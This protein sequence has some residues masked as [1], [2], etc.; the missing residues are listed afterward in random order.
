MTK[1]TQRDISVVEIF[2]PAILIGLTI[3]ETEG[4]LRNDVS[5]QSRKCVGNA[6]NSAI[7]PAA[8]E[9]LTEELGLALDQFL[10]IEDCFP[11]E[12]KSRGAQSV[13]EAEEHGFTDNGFSGA[14]SIR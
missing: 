10:L 5:A 7:C 8:I 9:S 11:G 2:F 6:E 3:R 14:R 4:V 1:C 12:A 13:V